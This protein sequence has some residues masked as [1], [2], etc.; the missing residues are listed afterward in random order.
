MSTN[1]RNV[2]AKRQPRRRGNRGRFG[3]GAKAILMTLVG[4]A[5]L[6]VVFYVSN[7][8]EEGLGSALA[9]RYPYEVGDPGPGEVAPPVNLPT[10][11]GG[12][13]ELASL[14]GESV[15]LYFQEGAMC[16]PCW[17]QLRDIERQWNEFEALGIDRIISITTDPLGVL[18]RKG[19]VEALETPLLS[20]S[21]LTVSNAYTTNRYG[22][23]GRGYNGHSFVLVDPDGVIRWRADYGG[24]PEYTM[25]LP[26]QNL[27]GDLR[28]G[29]E[30]A[31]N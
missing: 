1:G 9:G 22:M 28:R 11:D 21:D 31:E 14:R 5:V 2:S 4:V 29:L 17:D 23:M 6:G 13:F 10:A 20:D 19:A 27:L 25:Y 30:R 26:V 16:Q 18:S 7:S 12:T 15:L 8:G 24:P 3:T